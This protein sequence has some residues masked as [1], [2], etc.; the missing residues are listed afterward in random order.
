[1]DPGLAMKEHTRLER[2]STN[3]KG[4]GCALHFQQQPS[5]HLPP[6]LGANRKAKC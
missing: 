5:A 6:S 2:L 3:W 1:M 4:G